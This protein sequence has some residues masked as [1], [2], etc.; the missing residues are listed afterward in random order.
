MAQANFSCPYDIT[1]IRNLGYV[2]CMDILE[3]IDTKG[4]EELEELQDLIIELIRQSQNVEDGQSVPG[5]AGDDSQAKFSCPYDITEIR[6]LGYVKCMDILELIDTKGLEELEEL[7]DLII[8]LIKQSENVADGQ[9]A[10]G[11]AGDDSQATFTSAKWEVRVMGGLVEWLTLRPSTQAAGVRSSKSS[12][13]WIFIESVFL[14]PWEVRVKPMHIFSKVTPEIYIC[15]SAD[16]MNQIISRDRE[17][18]QKLNGIYGDLKSFFKM[19]Q[20]ASD[21]SLQHELEIE[22]KNVQEMVEE[23][24]KEL[25]RDECPIVVTGE[26]S[27]GKSSLLNLILGSNILPSSLRSNTSTVCRLHNHEQKMIKVYDQ[28]GKK[29][30]HHGVFDY[31]I[32]DDVLKK[33]MQK[34]ISCEENPY[35]YVDIFWPIPFLGSQVVIVDTPGI[36][37]NSE[38]TSR[39]LDYLPKAVA[40]IYVI[41]SENA[42]GVQQDR[43]LRILDEQ[44]K[45]REKGRNQ[46][47]DHNCTLF[48][49]NKWDEVPESERDRVWNNTKEKLRCWPGFTESQMFR[50]SALEAERRYRN[51]LD[52]TEDFQNLLRGIQ[53]MVPASFQEKVRQHAWWQEKLLKQILFH[54]TAHIN[55]TRL[56]QEE[57][58]IKKEKVEERL[59]RLDCDTEQ[60]KKTLKDEA[61]TRWAEVSEKLHAYIHDQETVEK[62]KEWDIHT[63]IP[64]RESDFDLIER[65][66]KEIILDKIGKEIKSW[67]E[68]ERSLSNIRNEL[69]NRFREEYRL[70]EGQCQDIDNLV[71]DV[72]GSIELDDVNVQETEPSH[73]IHSLLGKNS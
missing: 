26:T 47:F 31:N 20:Y 28:S 42:G 8:K 55:N 6:N 13:A 54:V 14:L 7:Q 43:L 71:Q 16:L 40:F 45:W 63:E 57:K 37:E 46:T 56:S 65:E 25:M 11:E 1:E 2:E 19:S 69:A 34:Y 33:E 4:L 36:G 39:L 52:Y 44:N 21:P 51:G 67:C 15:S 23:Y 30:V 48:V 24:S 50:L 59:R 70:L 62:L 12:Y 32:S 49:C 61:K 38:M 10:P 5:E 18:K 35:R 58:R 64:E 53:K 73:R 66:A 9:S 41:N 72:E 3:L 60:V 29:L 27:A 68:N 22:F 17:I